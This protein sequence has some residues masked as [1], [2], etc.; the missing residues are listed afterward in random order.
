MRQR[1]TEGEKIHQMLK[2]G[3]SAKDCNPIPGHVPY[4]PWN[5]PGQ[6]TRVG[7]CSLLQGNLPNSGI[8][9]RSPALQE[10]SL[11][12]E[13]PGKP[14]A[15][16]KDTCTPVFTEALFTTARTWKQPRCPSTGEWIKKW[17]MYTMEYYSATK[18]NKIGSF[19]ETWM[20]PETRRN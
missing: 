3:G 10:D 20:D 4:S 9:P 15:I 2:E 14:I 18:K 13:P 8:E 6:N 5:S 1:E 7:S 19:L 16:V 12:A 11:P 17:D